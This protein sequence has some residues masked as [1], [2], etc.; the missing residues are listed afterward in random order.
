MGNPNCCF[1]II[2]GAFFLQSTQLPKG[3][4]QS[5][6]AKKCIKRLFSFRFQSIPVKY[7]LTAKCILKRIRIPDISKMAQQ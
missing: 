5:T 7:L 6:N 2:V 1:M 3:T 4:V